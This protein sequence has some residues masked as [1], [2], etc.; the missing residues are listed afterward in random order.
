MKLLHT[1]DWQLGL[2]L[3]FLSE[4]GG[5]RERARLRRYEVVRELA[6]LAHR[7]KVDAVVVAGDVFDDNAVGPGTLQQA[8]DALAAFDSIPV[9][10]LPGNHDPL[11]PDS[12]LLRL[13]AA[14][15]VHILDT[16]DP[17]SLG[18][19]LFYPAPLT[20]HLYRDDPSRHLPTLPAQR[21][22]F[23]VVVAHG[24]VSHFGESERESSAIIDTRRILDKGYDYVALGDWHGLKEIDPRVW[25]PGT[26]EATRSKEK[27]PGYAL[28]V[29]LDSPGSIPVVEPLRVGRSQW[30]RDRRHLSAAG[31]LER[32]L[33][34][35][36]ALP[37]RSWTSL[38]A[39][40]SGTIDLQESSRLHAWMEKREGEFLHMAI[41]LE[42]L[43]ETVDVEAL[44][45][46]SDLTGIVAETV[47]SLQQ[48][49]SEASR[50]A[51]RV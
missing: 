47:D 25:Y 45:V 12:V 51:L 19:T 23:A 31:D 17:V 18:E 15:M 41:S 20:S 36:D 3:R 26:P 13:E 1:A 43:I 2:K 4:E 27:K 37:E 14:P 8:R 9:L 42:D 28:L 44:S 10:L 16:T 21:E 29:T 40:L 11:T 5:R 48:E 50:D 6:E 7:E 32:M 22:R 24:G 46:G 35:W 30:V 34:E 33:S 38:K 49:E 39:W